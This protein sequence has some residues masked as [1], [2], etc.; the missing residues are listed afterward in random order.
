MNDVSLLNLPAP[1]LD[2]LLGEARQRLVRYLLRWGHYDALQR[3]LDRWLAAQPASVTLRENRARVLFELGQHAEALAMIDTIDAERGASNTRRQFRLRALIAMARYDAATA[4]LDRL[5]ADPY[6]QLYVW[7]QRGDIARAQERLDEAA[8]AYTEAAMLDPAS[9]APVRRLAV[10]ALQQ[11]DAEAARGQIDALMLRPDFSPAV[12]DLEILRDAAHLAGDT[13]G[14]AALLAQLAERKRQEYEPI[15]A[16]LGLRMARHASDADDGLVEPATP[17][18]RPL[19]DETYT[20]LR[21]GF[22]LSEFRP[23]QSRVIASV[24]AGHNTLAVMPTGA[25]KS[26]TYQLPAMLLPRATVVVSPLI[27]L[28]K[29]QIDS[30]PD[31]VR[32]HA[33]MINSS[34]S[35]AEVAA[36]MRG[37]ADGRYRLVY[38]A[39]ER[40]RQR[41]FLHA[42]KRC[43]LSLFVVDEVHCISLWGLSF[44]PDYLFIG[45]A[46]EELGNPPLLALTATASRETQAEIRATLGA[47]ELVSASVFRPN[48]SFQV[49]RAGNTDDKQ[50]ALVTLCK[51]I[52]GPIIVYARARQTCE[53]LAAILRR[54]G[55]AAD[56]YHA[57]AEDRSGAQ[58]RFMRGQTRVLVATVAFGMGIDKA[59]IRA[60]IHYNLPQSVEAYYQEAG[61]AGRDGQLA[62]CILLYAASDKSRMTQWLHEEAITRDQLRELYREIRRAVRRTYDIVN[63]DE[64][65]RAVQVENE[66]F[67][68]VGLSMLE[69]VGL[70]RRHFDLPRTATL[71]LRD[72]VLADEAARQASELA[73]L[74][75]G[76]PTEVNLLELAGTAGWSPSELEGRLLEWQDA[77]YLRYQGMGRDALLELLAPAPDVGERIDRLLADYQQRQDQRVETIGAYARSA[78]CRHRALAAHFGQRLAACR[79]ACD[80]CAAEHGAAIPVPQAARRSAPAPLPPRNDADARSDAQRALDGLANLPFPMGRSGLAKVLKGASGSPVEPERCPEYAALSHLPLSR[81]EDLI[82]Q[83]VEAGYITRD[84]RHE[85]RGLSLSPLGRRARQDAASLPEWV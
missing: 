20:M 29:D 4:L 49:V 2:L 26:L 35:G 58:E 53:E 51:R 69:Q 83:L 41:P 64:L 81:I 24:L 22:G 55:V 70:L 8:A 37:I 67:A 17:A 60:I 80:N 3:Y 65:Q 71:T 61:R 9:P 10:L 50:Q 82:E 7:L 77:G 73:G 40:L 45:R 18:E 12:E 46:L 15:A 19:P 52:A 11:G 78:Q 59:D 85:H 31:A 48:L 16:E 23:N 6:Q 84:E 54:S 47:T 27:A 43:G 1:A 66:T 68:R 63:L 44:R 74:L 36:R 5:A 39:P 79:T 56:F 57:Q 72:G 75:P 32:E 76:V 42:L 33:T 38:I 14:E 21:E 62:H 30:L 28:M 13:E 25:G 34:L